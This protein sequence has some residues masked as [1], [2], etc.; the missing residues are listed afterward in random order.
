MKK[1]IVPTAV[2]LAA[3]LA[4]LCVAFVLRNKSQYDQT[5]TRLPAAYAVTP[6]DQN[7][8]SLLSEARSNWTC[9]ADSTN[10]PDSDIVRLAGLTPSVDNLIR[11]FN[12][13]M[14]DYCWW[15]P[16]R[17][18]K[19]LESAL[20]KARFLPASIDRT[21]HVSADRHEAV[22]RCKTNAMFVFS[23]APSGLRAALYLEK[24]KRIE[25]GGPT[26][27]ADE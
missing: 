1:L 14:P 18:R 16:V 8:L 26:N 6:M 7:L 3:I 4:G 11:V 15:S 23:D 24:R 5:R 10:G 19:A 22:V 25:P 27:P 17:N 21:F 13:Q 9:K 12:Y 2:A 20:I